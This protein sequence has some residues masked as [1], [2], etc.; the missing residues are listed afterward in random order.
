M[1][2]RGICINEGWGSEA[3]LEETGCESWSYWPKPYSSRT[4]PDGA[5]PKSIIEML[6][7]FPAEEEHCTLLAKREQTLNSRVRLQM[8]TRQP[9]TPPRWQTQASSEWWLQFCPLLC[10]DAASFLL[11]LTCHGL[12]NQGWLELDMSCRVPPGIW[13]H[14]RSLLASYTQD[15]GTLPT[16]SFWFW[17][18]PVY[19]VAVSV[20]TS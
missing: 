14:F 3:Q 5:V 19:T 6:L 8:L 20:I 18:V 7:V 11:C 12:L 17:P 4:T 1:H 9:R 16:F 13:L 10:G 15:V 2:R